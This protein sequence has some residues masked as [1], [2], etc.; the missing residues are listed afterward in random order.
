MA[1]LFLGIWFIFMVGKGV[2]CGLR[3]CRLQ[4]FGLVKRVEKMCRYWK[5]RVRSPMAWM[6]VLQDGST[7]SISNFL[8][9]LNNAL[10]KVAKGKFFL[11]ANSR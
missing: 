10:S 2:I 6:L 11:I 1:P 9:A 4:E 3:S 7:I 8:A 5:K